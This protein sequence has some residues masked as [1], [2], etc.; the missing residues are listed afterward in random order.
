[1]IV[2]FKQ[3]KNLFVVDYIFEWDEDIKYGSHYHVMLPG[4]KGK[5]DGKHYWPGEVVPEPW[6]STYF[7]G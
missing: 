1:M 6:N 7:G 3:S 2:R 4:S 5:H